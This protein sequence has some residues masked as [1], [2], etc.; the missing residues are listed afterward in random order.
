MVVLYQ[1]MPPPAYTVRSGVS[2][3][4][5]V[6]GH[7]LSSSAPLK[8][9]SCRYC[10][11]I[12]R[13]STLGSAVPRSASPRIG[14]ALSVSFAAVIPNEGMISAACAFIAA[15]IINAAR[16]AKAAAIN[17]FLFLSILI[18]ASNSR[19]PGVPPRTTLGGNMPAGESEYPGSCQRLTGGSPTHFEGL[20]TG[21]GRFWGFFEV[22]GGYRVPHGT[23]VATCTV[24][25]FPRGRMLP[26]RGAKVLVHLGG[27]REDRIL[28]LRGEEIEGRLVLQPGVV[29]G[30]DRAG[31]GLAG[32]AVQT[33]AVGAQ[34]ILQRVD[35]DAVEIRRHRGLG[36]GGRHGIH[37]EN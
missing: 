12:S 5:A 2:Q 31:P 27:P 37:V 25:I 29:I 26:Q 23:G 19:V 36:Q 20:E 1:P 6:M 35:P 10:P 14:L 22:L 33:P 7:I 30:V 32:H 9:S 11:L 28:L 17:A 13:S 24:Q 34:E 16:E 15:H 18:A 3:A 21:N 4:E 8:R